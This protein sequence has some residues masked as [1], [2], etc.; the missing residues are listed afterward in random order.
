MDILDP[1][2]ESEAGNLY[3]LVIGDYFTHCMEIYSIPIKQLQYNYSEY[4]NHW[5][6]LLSE[7]LNYTQVKVDSLNLN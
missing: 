5:T 3:I 7:Q 2:P 6:V 1:P 4:N